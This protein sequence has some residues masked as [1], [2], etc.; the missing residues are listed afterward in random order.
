MASS[1]SRPS[2][3]GAARL[4]RVTEHET[5]DLVFRLEERKYGRRLNSMELAQKADVP[6]DDVNRVERQLPLP[7]EEVVEKIAN[8]LGISPELLCKIAGQT[9]MTGTELEI[10]ESCFCLSANGE[11]VP[12]ECL[13]LGFRQIYR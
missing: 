8:A 13:R 12:S 1:S 7:S 3:L 9:E 10:L 6:L 2:H 4:R 11:P 5:N